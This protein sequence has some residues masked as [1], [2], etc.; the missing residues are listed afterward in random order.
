MP[1]VGTILI[2]L[3]AIGFVF[4]AVFLGIFSCK[5]TAIA[6]EQNVYEQ[7]DV[8]SVMQNE[9]FNSL[10]QL[11][12]TVK[13]YKNYEGE[14]LA[15]I[16]GMRVGGTSSAAIAKNSETLSKANEQARIYIN[17]VHE[18]YPE[19]KAEKLYSEFMTA[20]QRY[21]SK[22]AQAQKEYARVKRQYNICIR[23]FPRSAILDWLGYAKITFEDLYDGSSVKLPNQGKPKLFEE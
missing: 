4:L 9:M 19:L 10:E 8:I 21:N 16:V 22:V 17:A 3:G 18:A 13:D 6:K 15:K 11:V 7:L 5:N 14:A 20:I 12:S 1:K 23:A 2:T